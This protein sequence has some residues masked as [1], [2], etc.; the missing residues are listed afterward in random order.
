VSSDVIAALIGALVGGAIS[1]L[2]GWLLQRNA[3]NRRENRMREL[4]KT[5]LLDDLNNAE[6]LF[7]RLRDDLDKTGLVWQVTLNEIYA[8]R[9]LYWKYKEHLVLIDAKLRKEISSYYLRTQ[10]SLVLLDNSQKFKDNMADRTREITQRLVIESHQNPVQAEQI[11]AEV[12]RDSG[13]QL[14]HAERAIGQ[15]IGK[16]TAQIP[17]AKRL[18]TNVANA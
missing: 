6:E 13:E 10:Q 5:I 2:A 18:T 9:D 7:G 8:S 16:L 3:D 12:L 14:N 4:F 1:L 15:E 11:A 17:E